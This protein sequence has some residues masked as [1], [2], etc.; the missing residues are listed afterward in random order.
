MSEINT[1]T[2]SNV[3]AIAPTSKPSKMPLRAKIGWT[4]SV[5]IMMFLTFSAGAKFSRFEGREEMFAKMGWDSEVMY[6]IGIV[7]IIVG[8]AFL[9]PQTAF[10]GAILL[11]GY[12]GG[13]IATHVRVH[14][15]FLF[16][17]ALGVIVW[18]ALALRDPRIISLVY[19][20]VEDVPDKS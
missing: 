7:E 4:L 16:P 19:D 18:I 11:T 17:I 2:P 10:I 1:P 20:N 3:S 9:V 12:L 13:A 6:Y 14:D 5:L 8:L 15:P